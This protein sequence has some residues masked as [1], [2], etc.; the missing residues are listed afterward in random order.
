MDSA[1]GIGV[2]AS[3]WCTLA[4]VVKQDTSVPYTVANEYICGSLGQAVGLPVP[5]GTIAKLNDDSY[6]YVAL[7]FGIKGDSL[8]PVDAAAMVLAK[9]TTAAGIAV[10]DCWI[11]NSDRHNGNLAFS[12]AS[13]TVSMFDH[14]HSLLGPNAGNGIAHLDGLRDQPYWYGCLPPELQ[15]ST[16]LHRWAE[17]ISSV[18]DDLLAEIPQRAADLRL[19]SPPEAAKISEVLTFRK[20]RL[21]DY[22]DQSKASFPKVNDWGGGVL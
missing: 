13:G 8:P 18:H 17:R 21:A 1:I 20:K 3:S 15:Y 7:K 5:P 4:G 6:A 22:L 9:P 19:C 10:F 11:L 12:P 2:T 14:G 16:H